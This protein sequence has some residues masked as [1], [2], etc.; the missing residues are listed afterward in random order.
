MTGN[1]TVWRFDTPDGAEETMHA[2]EKLAREDRPLRVSPPGLKR[3]NFSST[4]AVDE[5]P[6]TTTGST[7]S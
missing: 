4:E 5:K 3:P 7:P 6:L 2:L 1:L